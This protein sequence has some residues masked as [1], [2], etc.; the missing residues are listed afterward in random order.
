MAGAWRGRPLE[1]EHVLLVLFE[2]DHVGEPLDGRL[3][4]QRAC[5]LWPRARPCRIGFSGVANSTEGSRNLG[6]ELLAQSWASPSYQ[7]AALRS[8]ARASECSPRRTPLFEFLQDLGPRDLPA[9]R[10]NVAFGDLS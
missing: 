9:D 6:D 2:R 4:D 5:G 8:S 10:W 3:A 1:D 7:S